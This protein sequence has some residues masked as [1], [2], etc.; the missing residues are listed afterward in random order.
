MA[1]LCFVNRSFSSQLVIAGE[2]DKQIDGDEEG[3]WHI[4]MG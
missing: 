4:A 3:G 1:E 2:V